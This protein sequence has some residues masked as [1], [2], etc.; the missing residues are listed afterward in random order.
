[1][2]LTWKFGRLGS[3][4]TMNGVYLRLRYAEPWAYVSTLVRPSSAPEMT[5]GRP[6][7]MCS[8]ILETMVHTAG[9]SL[10]VSVGVAGMRPVITR[11]L[12]PP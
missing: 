11:L 3:S 10:T 5:F 9:A 7:S 12:P 1:M 8:R 6:M 4:P 2:F